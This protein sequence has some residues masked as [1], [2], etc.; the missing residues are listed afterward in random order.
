MNMYK[1]LAIAALSTVV[2]SVPAQAMPAIYWNL[3][4]V[5]GNSTQSAQFRTY[6]N[7][8]DMLANTNFTLGPFPIPGVG[9]SIVGSGSDGTTYWN[10]VNVEGNSTQSAQFRTYTNLPDMLAN[11]NFTLGPFPIPGV[12]TSI[13]GSGAILLVGPGPNPVPEPATLALFAFG[14]VGLGFTRRR[15]FTT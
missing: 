4:N 15:R 1:S 8:T 5:E 11:T 7:L 6:T 9:P 3:V 10:L 2:F 12:G 13:V 14:L